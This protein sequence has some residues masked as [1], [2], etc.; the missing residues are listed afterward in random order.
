MAQPQVAVY[1]DFDNV[2]LSR[3]QQAR[4]SGAVSR[5]KLREMSLEDLHKNQ[6]FMESRFDVD[7]VIDF[8]ASLGSVVLTRAY[9]D[10]SLPTMASFAADLLSRAVDLTQVFPLGNRAKN[11]ADIRIAVDVVEDLFRL[12]QVTHVVLAS[13]DSDFVA[14]AQRVRRLGRQMVGVGIVG[15]VGK[16]LAGAFDRYVSYDDLPG[17]KPLAIRGTDNAKA[18]A[19]DVEKV[20]AATKTGKLVPKNGPSGVLYRALVSLKASSDDDAS[21]FPLGLV[22]NSMLQLDPS[23][24]EKRLNYAN[25]TKFLESRQG[26]VELDNSTPQ[27]KARLRS[28]E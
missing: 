20:V 5:D 11:G 1:I 15:S 17:V 13:G 6:D 3:Y 27:T 21:W 28:K 19:N 22:K 14:L 16:N 2:V 25:F 12:P 18:D 7:A 9:G 10:F 23:F 8:A 24:S 4:G 26:F